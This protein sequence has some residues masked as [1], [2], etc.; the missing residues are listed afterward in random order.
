MLSLHSVN[1]NPF[2][3]IMIINGLVYEGRIVLG[4]SY[5]VSMIQLG[6]N[7]PGGIY[8]NEE[9][10]KVDTNADEMVR[11]ALRLHAKRIC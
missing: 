3:R 9:N 4:H 6:Q 1:I 5:L 11:V 2:S 10:S 7:N 8:A